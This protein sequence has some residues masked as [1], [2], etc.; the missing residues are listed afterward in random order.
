MNNEIEEFLEHS[1]IKPTVN[2]ILVT[3]AL[4][5]ANSPLSLTELETDLETL[6]KSSVS[7]VLSLL[8]ARGAIHMVEDGRG[9]A[10]YEIC[11]AE[12]KC[13]PSHFHAHFY[14]EKCQHTYCLDEIKVSEPQLPAGFSALSVNYMIKGICKNCNNSLMP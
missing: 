3:K 6:E 11:H 2:R 14:C 1:R 4:M 5:K 13:T 10:K 7:R 12:G 8:L 9:I